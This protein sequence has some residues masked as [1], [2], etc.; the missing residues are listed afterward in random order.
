M[1]GEAAQPGGARSRQRIT[2]T[3]NPDRSVRQLWD[4]A[5]GAGEWTVV[6]DGRY[7]RK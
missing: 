5:N 1:Q 4:A 3:P 2:G 6:F 7:T